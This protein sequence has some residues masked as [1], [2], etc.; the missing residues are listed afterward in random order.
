V[1]SIFLGKLDLSLKK[2]KSVQLWKDDERIS[3]DLKFIHEE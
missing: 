1:E 2:S 3:F